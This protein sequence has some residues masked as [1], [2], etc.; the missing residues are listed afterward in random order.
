MATTAR[1]SGSAKKTTKKSASTGKSAPAKKSA[2]KK[3]TSAR[4]SESSSSTRESRSG[5][6]RQK[7]PVAE[8]ARAG[9]RQLLELTGAEVEGVTG[10]ERTEDGWTVLVEVLELRRVPNSTDLLALYAV[11]VDADGDLLGY[12]RVRRYVRGQPDEDRR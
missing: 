7:T 3:A 2:A 6:S 1:N 8:I 11:D 12:H 5:G 4:R 9:A 10:L